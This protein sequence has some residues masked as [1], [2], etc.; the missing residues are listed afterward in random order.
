MATILASSCGHWHT[1]VLGQQRPERSRIFFLPCVTLN[2]I[3]SYVFRKTPELPSA[4]HLLLRTQNQTVQVVGFLKFR[5][6]EC[7]MYKCFFFLQTMTIAFCTQYDYFACTWLSL[8]VIED[9]SNLNNPIDS[10]H[11]THIKIPTLINMKAG[12]RQ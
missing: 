11:G 12:E 7:T 9:C 1:Q 5:V 3:I 4:S 10:A 8:W 2:N 6:I